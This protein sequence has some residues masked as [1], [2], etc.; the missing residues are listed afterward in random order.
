MKSVNRD[1]YK[2][3]CSLCNKDF[4]IASGGAILQ[5]PLPATITGFPW[6]E[7][8]VIRPMGQAYASY[9]WGFYTNSRTY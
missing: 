5:N 3:R 6:F 2:A 4:S 9:I 8:E 7:W 1:K